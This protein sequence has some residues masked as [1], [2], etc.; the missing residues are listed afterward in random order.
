MSR[1]P[2]GLV[3]HLAGHPVHFIENSARLNHSD[4]ILRIAFSFAHTSLCWL[5][6]DRLI[7]ENPS[8][9]LPAPFDMPGNRNSGRFDLT[10]RDPPRL[11]SLETE[12]AESNFPPAIRL[13]AHAAFLGLTKL[14]FLWCEHPTLSPSSHHRWNG[15]R[16]R[17]AGEHVSPALPVRRSILD[18]IRLRFFEVGRI[19]PRRGKSRS[20]HRS[21]PLWYGPRQ[22]HNQ[23]PL[24][25]CG[26]APDLPDTIPYERFLRLP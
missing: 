14:N 7:G 5:F 15:K 20:S 10:A 19:P 17:T 8:P 25:A 1:Q 11:Q 2:Q 22:I 23:C 24:E 26:A 9:D 21:A 18:R 16:S 6:R 4:P 13:A 12:F 3:S